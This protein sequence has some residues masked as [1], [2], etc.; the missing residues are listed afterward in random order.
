MVELLKSRGLLLA[1]EASDDHSN[2]QTEPVNIEAI[3]YDVGNAIYEHICKNYVLL[4]PFSGV[5]L[6]HF[7]FSTYS[8]RALDREQHIHRL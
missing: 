1:G 2:H 8:L 3:Q 7:A 5:I 4:N 6:R